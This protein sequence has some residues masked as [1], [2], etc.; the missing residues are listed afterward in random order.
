MSAMG[1]TGLREAARQCYDKAHYA[2]EQIAALK[3][4][5]LAFDGPFFN[6]FAVDG[7]VA[8]EKVIALGRQRG[9]MPGLDCSKL[10][11]SSP[12]IGPVSRLLIAVTEKRSRA[13]IDGLAALL[14][15]AGSS[16]G[17]GSV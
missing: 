2:A 15:D 3:G 6:E 16:A 4:W 12:G 5:S 1:P 17:K 10:G 14:A 11:C 7:P 8:A 13:E 9:I